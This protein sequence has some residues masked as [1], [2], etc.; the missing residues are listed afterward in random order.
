MKLQREPYWDYMGRRLREERMKEKD[1]DFIGVYHP[2]PNERKGAKDINQ[3]DLFKDY[4]P[5]KLPW[6]KRLFSKKN[7]KFL[8]DWRFF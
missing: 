6:W 3:L 8:G 2:F 4:S 5:P 1:D 7:K